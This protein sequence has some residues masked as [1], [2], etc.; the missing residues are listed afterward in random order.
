M[1]LTDSGRIPT[2][3]LVQA[4][5]A[6][7]GDAL[8]TPEA[9][10]TI[11]DLARALPDVAC[12]IG[13]ECALAAG[14]DRLDLG[15]SVTPASGGAL[16]LAGATADPVLQQAVALDPRW[17]RLQRFAQHWCQ[18][19]APLCARIPFLFLEFDGA[20][21]RQ[22]VPIPSVF[23]A[24]DWQLDELAAGNRGATTSL[25][26]AH[27]RQLL[28]LLRDGSVASP[29]DGTLTRCFEQLPPGGLVLH[30][31]AMLGRPRS[32]ARL[33]V[34]LPRAVATHYLR[35]LGWDTSVSQLD[36]EIAALAGAAHFDHP[37]ARVQLD[38]DV[39]ELG[40]RVGLTLQPRNA[41][42]WPA[43]VAR[44]QHQGRC[45]P[46]RGAATLAWPGLR[47]AWLPGT[48]TP[49]VLSRYMMHLKLSLLGGRGPEVKAYFGGR[50][51]S[52][53]RRSQRAASPVD[54][55]VETG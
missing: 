8:V 32:A 7:L 14:D 35:D 4:L 40:G 21:P 42:S 26:L 1:A 45:D 22:P 30:V 44:V 24:F 43:L 17:A 37:A 54:T 51:V 48:S 53:P 33:S 5:S 23:A 38:F 27:A 49:C 10:E 47:A 41:S 29:D 16:A 50:S 36:A 19:G 12:S 52:T 20:G 34:S 46:E 25:G 28:E 13:F 6:D 31:A 39:L 11:V 3:V 9:R 55:G 15:V 18:P 2:G